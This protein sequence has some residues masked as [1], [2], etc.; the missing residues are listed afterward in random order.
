MH[1]MAAILCAKV[2]APKA[3]VKE[4]YLYA[5][6][7][8]VDALSHRQKQKKQAL[9]DQPGVVYCSAENL[10][11]LMQTGFG[12]KQFGPAAGMAS[13]AAN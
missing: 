10:T 4:N 1:R 8:F 3:E 2:E 5:I 11:G 7:H 13:G 9:H 6:N 12:K